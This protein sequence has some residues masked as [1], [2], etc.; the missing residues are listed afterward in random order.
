M[1][2]SPRGRLL[3]VL[4]V[5]AACAAFA[6]LSTASDSDNYK[7]VDGVGIYFGLMPSGSRKDNFTVALFDNSTGKRITDARVTATIGEIGVSAETKVLEPLKIGEAVTYG[8]SFDMPDNAMY[9]FRLKIQIP[10]RPKTI[11]T[12]FTQQH[13]AQ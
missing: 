10:G 2:K 4:L 11:E 7:V 12:E 9:R 13:Y 5:A 6:N 3:S 8:N 1:L